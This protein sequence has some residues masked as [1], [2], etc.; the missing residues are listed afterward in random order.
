MRWLGFH[1]LC[2]YL[3]DVISTNIVYSMMKLLYLKPLFLYIS[4]LS[5]LSFLLSFKKIMLCNAE[6]YFNCN[7]CRI[8]ARSS[9]GELPQLTLRLE[10]RASCFNH[11]CLAGNLTV[12]SGLHDVYK[13]YI[14]LIPSLYVLY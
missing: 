5:G 2:D 14:R 3:I 7:V 10:V 9:F 12:L 11:H 8:S 4:F 6:H 1:Y 13:R